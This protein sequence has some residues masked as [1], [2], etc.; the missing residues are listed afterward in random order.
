MFLYNFN[1][2]TRN[3]W[4]DAKIPRRGI[5]TSTR[6]FTKGTEYDFRHAD[7]Q[8]NA[9]KIRVIIITNEPTVGISSRVESIV[10]YI[11]TNMITPRK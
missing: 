9:L 8:R 7:Y 5:K 6:E 4:C 10:I 11:S 1:S 2:F 3:G